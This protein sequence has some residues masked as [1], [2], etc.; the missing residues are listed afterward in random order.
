MSNFSRVIVSF[1]IIAAV[2]SLASADDSPIKVGATLELN[3]TF[4]SNNPPST[5]VPTGLYGG[6][7]SYF[8]KKSGEV[9]LNY[10]EIHIYKDKT[11][12][13]PGFSIRY[14]DG[15]IKPGLPVNAAN[16][17]TSTGNLYEA[18]ISEQLTSKLSVDAGIFPTWVGYETIPMGTG[19][20]FTKSFHFGQFQPFYHGGVKANL[21]LSAK[22]TLVGAIVNRFS[23]V[24]TNG[25]KDLGMGFQFAHVI[26]DASTLYVN[27]L[28][29]RDTLQTG[30]AGGAPVFSE[31]Q[32]NIANIVYTR[33]LSGTSN[34]ALDASVTNGKDG[35]NKKYNGQAVTGYYTYTMTNGNTVGLRAESLSGDANTPWLALGGTGK[36]QLSSVTASYELKSS[37]KGIRTLIEARFDSANTAIFPTKTAAKK[38]Q[39][40]VSLAH[41]LSF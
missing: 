29:S 41:V 23:G 3:Y 37:Q 19:N 13:E 11:A 17:N 25:N 4:N 18:V 34:F 8:N 35:T 5:A 10:G 14:V 22:D 33:K 40:T 39:T 15:E 31:M 16:Y 12:K 30:T 6:N 24:E 7:G 26:S 32:R 28:T 1:S 36:P 2:A 21:T 38:N 20:F 27:G 9:V